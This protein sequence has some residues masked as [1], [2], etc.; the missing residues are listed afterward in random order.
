[1]IRVLLVDDHPILRAGVRDLLQQDPGIAVVGE[2]ASAED[3]QA[4]LKDVE[5]DVLLLDISLPGQSGVDLLHQLR[6]ERPTLAVLFLSMYPESTFAVP[7]LRAGAAG[8]ITKTAQPDE[9]VRAVR[10]AGTGQKYIGTAVAEL[11]CATIGSPV[12]PTPHLKLSPREMQIFTRIAKGLAPAAMADELSL[13]VKTIGT[14][15]TRILEKMGLS[16]NAELAAYAV[17]NQLLE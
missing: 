15:R 3:A 1:M 5:V 9:L 13:S 2:A 10:A 17:R 4:L 7:L 11:L 16:S 12:E 8:Y 6:R 14:Y